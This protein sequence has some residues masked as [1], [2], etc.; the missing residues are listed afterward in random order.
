M[1]TDLSEIRRRTEEQG[2]ENLAFRRFL[3][4]HHYSDETFRILAEDVSQQIDCTA[5]ANCCRQT[6][7]NVTPEE[8]SAIADY[9]HMEFE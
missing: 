8:I 4:K 1:V 3:R 9:L 2:R 6:V 7:V 5:C